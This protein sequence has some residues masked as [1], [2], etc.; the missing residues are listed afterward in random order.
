MTKKEFA[1]WQENP[2]KFL[3]ASLIYIH[4]YKDAFINSARI[5]KSKNINTSNPDIK[6]ENYYFDLYTADKVIDVKFDDDTITL[7]TKIKH[8]YLDWEARKIKEC[9]VGEVVTNNFPRKNIKSIDI[10][11]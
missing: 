3:N 6:Y 1:Y 10:R 5:V 7:K 4:F 9:L 8:V 11:N 2:D